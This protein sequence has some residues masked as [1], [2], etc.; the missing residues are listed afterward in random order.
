MQPEKALEALNILELALTEC[1]GR[2]RF[3]AEETEN[4]KE[5][6]RLVRQATN[7]ELDT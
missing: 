1:K 2:G 4:A 6:L 3:T 5:L 7:E